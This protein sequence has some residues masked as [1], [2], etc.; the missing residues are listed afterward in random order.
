MAR[1]KTHHVFEVRSV[2]FLNVSVSL[3]AE[4]RLTMDL[5][6]KPTDTHQNLYWDSCHQQHCKFTIPY[7]QGLH[8]WRSCSGDNEYLT[9]VSELKSHLV[10]Q[11]YDETRVQRQIDKATNMSRSTALKEKENEPDK[12]GS[13]GG[14]LSS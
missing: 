4:G 14:D 12:K 11:G 3:D 5:Y 1:W 2:S 6:T 10:N 7:S 9:R 8:I 13:S